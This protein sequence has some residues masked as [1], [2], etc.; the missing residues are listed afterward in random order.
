M[1]FTSINSTKMNDKINT[2]KNKMKTHAVLLVYANWC[3]YCVQMKPAWEEVKTKM[4][5]VDFFE[6][7]SANIDAFMQ[8]APDVLGSQS[9]SYPT[10]MVYKSN[11][12]SPYTKDRTV[13]QMMKSFKNTSPAKSPTPKKS[14]K[15]PKKTSKK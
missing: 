6:L 15:T 7:E 9:I 3:P 10:I 1:V 5:N 12:M 4:T 2:L 13:E 11:K 14:P 8:R